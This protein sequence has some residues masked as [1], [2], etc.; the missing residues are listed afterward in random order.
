VLVGQAGA[1]GPVLGTP[2]G[3]L[4]LY[5]LSGRDLV[6]VDLDTGVVTVRQR[7]LD[8]G[9]TDSFNSAVM[10]LDGRLVVARDG[11]VFVATTDLDGDPEALDDVFFNGSL[12]PDRLVTMEWAS[13]PE[14]PLEVREFDAD[15]RLVNLW[16]LPAQSWAAGVVGDRVVAQAAGRIYLVAPDGD[17]EPVGVG[18]P[19]HVRNSH[20]LWRHCDDELRCSLSL[21]DLAN[22]TSQPVPHLDQGEYWF[23]GRTI[24]PDGRFASVMLGNTHRLIWLATGAELAELDARTQPAWSPDASW[25]FTRADDETLV[26]ISTRGEAPIEIALPDGFSLRDAEVFL[27]VG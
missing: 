23:F 7:A 12:S 21:A 9:F 22:G 1:G 13:S 11:R 20:I 24:A 17:V 4:S 25:V 5:A 19:V 15:G 6:R 8:R 16:N 27:T 18:E 2:T 3:G 26:A 10:V 14:D